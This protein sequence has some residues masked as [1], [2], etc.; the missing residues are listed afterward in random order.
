MG[1][2]NE[3]V[4]QKQLKFLLLSNW[5][6]TLDFHLTFYLGNCSVI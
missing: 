4:Q 1:W 2:A 6:D 3:M 5:L